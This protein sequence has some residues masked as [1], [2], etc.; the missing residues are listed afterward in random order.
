MKILIALIL[1]LISTNAFAVM[2]IYC[3]EEK[4]HLYDYQKDEIIIGDM[5][6]AEDFIPAMDIPQPQEQDPMGCPICE[7]PLNWYE[8]QAWVDHQKPPVFH[9]WAITLLTKE[10]GEF[11]WR[12]YNIE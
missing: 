1:L 9:C 7:A 3:P 8:Y 2:P 6:K 11:V 5:L 10:E 12:P 4:I